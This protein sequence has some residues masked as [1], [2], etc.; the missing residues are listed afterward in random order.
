M[1]Q[2]P[3]LKSLFWS[4]FRAQRHFI[5][6]LRRSGQVWFF[7]LVPLCGIQDLSSMLGVK[8]MS[9][10]HWTTRAVPEAGALVAPTC[11]CLS[12]GL[13]S[14]EGHP[15]SKAAPLSQILL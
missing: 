15:L 5:F 1:K 14:S 10:N 2:Q 3:F 6:I 4:T 8:P 13:L 11:G 7:F 12:A 9:L